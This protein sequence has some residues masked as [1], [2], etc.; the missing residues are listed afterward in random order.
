MHADGFQFGLLQGGPDTIEVVVGGL[1]F[2]V[3]DVLNA[4]EDCGG[5]VENDLSDRVQL[6]AE[7][8]LRKRISK[9]SLTRGGESGRLRNEGA[10]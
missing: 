7:I 5:I 3:A 10:A 9:T 6:N 8:V 1:H 2:G 4:F